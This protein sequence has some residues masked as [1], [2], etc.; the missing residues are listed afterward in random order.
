MTAI[1][2]T[3]MEKLNPNTLPSGSLLKRFHWG[4]LWVGFIAANA[5][6]PVCMVYTFLTRHITWAGVKYKRK[7]GKIISVEH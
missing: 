4:K 6:L 3:V 1:V 2:C 5:V 7:K